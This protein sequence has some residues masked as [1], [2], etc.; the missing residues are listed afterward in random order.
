M[1]SEVCLAP[2]QHCVISVCEAVIYI[3]EMPADLFNFFFFHYYCINIE[4]ERLMHGCSSLS[5]VLV[6]K[7][8]P[9]CGL[10]LSFVSISSW[11]K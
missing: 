4:L 5:R 2:E 7:H 11:E 6:C 8:K 9:G 3:C 10:S 1:Q